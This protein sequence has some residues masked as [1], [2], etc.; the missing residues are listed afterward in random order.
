MKR[1]CLLFLLLLPFFGAMAQS[2]SVKSFKALPMDLT[3]SSLEGKRIDQNG[4][5]AA[6]IKVVTNATGFVFE[7]GTLG[8]V[9]TKQETGEVWVWV[10]RASRKITIKH[11]KLGVLRS[12]VY[13]IEIEAERTYEMV[14]TTAKMETVFVDEV[15]EQFLMFRITP[16]DALL[17]VNEQVW[18]VSDDGIARKLVDFGSY[19][20]RVQAQNYHPYAGVVEVNDPNETQIVPI[21]LEPDY[22]WIA[23]AGDGNLKGAS[24]FVDNA[25]IGRAPC[26]SEAVKSGKHVVRIVKEMY[27]TY[28]ETVTVTDNET[29]NLAP[30]LSADFAHVTL[31]V[32]ADAEIWV[33]DEKKGVRAWSGDL[34]SGT[35]RI[36]CKQSNH[37]TTSTKMEITQKMNGQVIRLD[38]PLPFKGSLVVESTPDIADL[39]IDNDYVGQTPKLI[40]DMVVGQHE[41]RLTKEGYKEYTGLIIVKKNERT[42]VEPKLEALPKLK[43]KK[44][45]KPKKP[46]EEKKVEPKPKLDSIKAVNLRLSQIKPRPSKSHFVGVEGSMGGVVLFGDINSSPNPWEKALSWN[47]Q[48]AVYYGIGQLLKDYPVSVEAG[49]GFRSLPM[50]AT[51]NN[52]SGKIEDCDG[53]LYEPHFGDCSEKLTMNCLEIPVRICWGQPDNGKVSFYTKLGVT[54][55]FIL[56][57][58]LA[59]KYSNKGHYSQ[60]NVTFE[61]IEELGFT[62]VDDVVKVTPKDRKFNLW[63][64]VAFGVYVPLNSSLMFNVGAKLDCPILSTGTFII[65]DPKLPNVFSAG[66]INYNSRMLI[67]SLQAGMVYKL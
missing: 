35:Y 24:V 20:Y 53:D 51:I 54:P 11:P 3:A 64:N 19:T 6:L 45:E 27:S 39:Y 32:D 30:E 43:P 2:I 23:V 25:Y 26:K 14:L 15:N 59:Q 61:D 28:S 42:Q 16:H 29:L 38:A 36:E 10:P 60:W 57:S 21:N 58:S 7:G 17:E 41:L 66:L 44:E 22:G 65:N 37:E 18:P 49:V 46:K 63:G 4:D 56:S 31:Q 48:A 55:S 8:I 67:P 33:N 34:P 1:Y 50:K 47:K 62:N 40:K 52:V 9:D 5:V 12:Y 13:P